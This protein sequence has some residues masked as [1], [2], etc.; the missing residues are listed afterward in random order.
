[1]S[2]MKNDMDLLKSFIERSKLSLTNVAKELGIT[3]V[4]LNN[5]LKGRYAFTLE[6]ALTLK[7]LLELSQKEWDAVFN[8]R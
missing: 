6:E 8:K 4:A 1:L 5:K 7:K 3:Y 2:D